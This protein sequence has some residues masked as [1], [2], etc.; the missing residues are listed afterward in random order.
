MLP[1][2]NARLLSV[3]RAATGSTEDYDRP[4]TGEPTVWTGNIDAYVQRKMT[5]VFS[6][7]ELKRL[8]VVT[9]L[10]DDA[11]PV[12][13][14]DGDILTYSAGNPTSPT[15][16]AGV[17]QNATDPAFLAMLPDYYKCALEDTNI[18]GGSS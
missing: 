13:L 2:S 5:S 9:L 18:P 6:E 17:L 3:T 4:A 16:F 10:V 7:N 15:V 1:Q 8:L 11:L 14:E 12:P